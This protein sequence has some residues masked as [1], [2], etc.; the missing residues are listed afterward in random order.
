[1]TRS[2]FLVVLLS[3]LCFSLAATYQNPVWKED[4]ADPF[5]L[6]DGGNY[7]A[8]ATCYHNAGANVSINIPFLMS[9]DGSL[10]NWKYMGD[11]LPQLPS[12]AAANAGLTWAP[13]VLA[14]NGT[15]IMY[16]TSRFASSGLQ[17]ISYA[18]SSTPYG[19]F[20]DP[21]T[22]GP[23]LCQQSLGGS[24]DASPFVAPNGDLFLV[25]KNDGNCCGYTVNIWSQLLDSTGTSFAPGTSPKAL[26]TNDQPWEGNLVEGPSM[27]ALLNGTSYQYYLFYSANGYESYQYAVGYALCSS[28]TGPCHKPTYSPIISYYGSVWGPGGEQPFYDLNGNLWFCYH[29]WTA[30]DGT[31]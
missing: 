19:P 5:I 21:N 29:G 24:I 15:Y 7:F 6:V 23:W 9:T 1:M 16:Y 18:T 31:L 30:P 11:A 26:I 2:L 8:Y 12:W 13:A 28:P 10:T 14:N 25:W 27:L 3:V 20:V 17:C 4:F 22:A